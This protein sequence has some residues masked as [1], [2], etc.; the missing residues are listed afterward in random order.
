MS[1]VG[2]FPQ[3]GSRTAITT[4]EIC[5]RAGTQRAGLPGQPSVDILGGQ[6]G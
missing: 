4:S 1:D 3:P 5:H 6:F 2:C